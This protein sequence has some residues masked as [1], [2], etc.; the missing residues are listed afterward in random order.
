MWTIAIR[1][2]NA[3]IVFNRVNRT[4]Y[5]IITTCCRGTK[6]VFATRPGKRWKSLISNLYITTDYYRSIRDYFNSSVS[7]QSRIIV[8]DSH[9]ISSYSIRKRCWK[10][11]KKNIYVKMYIWIN[12]KTESIKLN[13]KRLLYEFFI[14]I[15]KMK[16]FRKEITRGNKIENT[17]DVTIKRRGVIKNNRILIYWTAENLC[18]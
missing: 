14:Y 1:N 10:L 2:K 16:L 6:I 18:I 17:M 9:Y 8:Y 13:K 3:L 4:R 7:R 11:K 12:E 15:K 5:D